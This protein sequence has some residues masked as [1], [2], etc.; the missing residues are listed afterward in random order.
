MCKGKCFCIEV[1]VVAYT[2]LGVNGLNSAFRLVNRYRPLHDM[3]FSAFTL[4]L[5]ICFIF[6]MFIDFLMDADRFG[7]HPMLRA[8]KVGRW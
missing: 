3:H 4:N 8:V 2:W 5:I 7:I 1:H 6:D